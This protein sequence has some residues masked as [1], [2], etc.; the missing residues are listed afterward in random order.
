MLVRRPIQNEPKEKP[1]KPKRTGDEKCSLP[2]IFELQPNNKWWGKHRSQCGAAVENRQ[3]EG[4]LANGKPFG[5]HFSRARPVPRFPQT[6]QEAKD[7]HA[8]Q[9]P[10]SC[11]EQ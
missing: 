10:R 3:T 6:K 8:G 9:S 11:V 4:P 5:D 1:N 7:T 2:S